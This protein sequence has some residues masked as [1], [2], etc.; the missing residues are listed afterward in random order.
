[1]NKIEIPC[2]KCGR[3]VWPGGPRL[4]LVHSS[5][6]SIFCKEELTDILAR[7]EETLKTETFEP[8][9]A[10][11]EDCYEDLGFLRHEKTNYV[12]CDPK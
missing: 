3:P 6:G 4:L 12:T 10:C 7:R 11:G 9:P 1:V 5:S 8:C 2:R